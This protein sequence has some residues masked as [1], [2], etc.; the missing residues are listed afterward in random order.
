[1]TGELEGRALLEAAKEW[2]ARTPGVLRAHVRGQSRES[3]SRRPSSRFWSQTEVLAH[4]ADF[5]VACFQARVEIILRG[6]PVLAVDPDRR[7]EEIPYATMDPF[8]S[9]ERFSRDRE[10]SLARVRQL[11]PDQ[12]T[13]R[14]VH[15]DLGEI[16]LENLLAEWTSH[17]LG[18]IRQLVVAAA[19]LFLPITGPWRP[20]YK[21]LELQLKT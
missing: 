12:L 1:M 13:R 6:E 2:L 4:L 14:A 21:H 11:S 16:T 5:E 9:L 17:D 20:G 15:S 7:A 19:Q 10:R 18:H 8:E 3:L